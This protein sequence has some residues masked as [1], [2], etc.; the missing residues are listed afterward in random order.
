MSKVQAHAR[1]KLIALLISENTIANH[2]TLSL[3]DLGCF[4]QYFLTSTPATSSEIKG[5][6][7]SDLSIVRKL[8]EGEHYDFKLNKC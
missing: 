7:V 4:S 3:R 1:H 5:K 2:F 6:K 8:C